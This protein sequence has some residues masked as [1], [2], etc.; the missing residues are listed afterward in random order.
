MF[1]IYSY[2]KGETMK[3]LKELDTQISLWYDYMNN[4]QIK[5]LHIQSDYQTRSF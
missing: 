3:N 1:I 4:N 5:D 2:I